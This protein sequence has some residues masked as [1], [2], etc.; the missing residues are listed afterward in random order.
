MYQKVVVILS[1]VSKT[2]EDF[3]LHG[4]AVD[5]TSFKRCTFREKDVPLI[6]VVTTA[7]L[8]LLIELG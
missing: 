2:E 1:Y 7:S 5:D 6:R 3:L 8:S 4:L